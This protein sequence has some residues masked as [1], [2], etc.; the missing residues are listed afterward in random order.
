MSE[1][2][3]YGFIRGRMP[4]LKVTKNPEKPEADEVLAES[5][6]ALDKAMTSFNKGPLK[7]NAIATLLMDST[8][9][10]K[11]TIYKVLDGLSNLKKHYCK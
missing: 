5:I 7:I 6:L 8:G 11:T 4:P 3:S 9:V 2:S 10:S 1:V